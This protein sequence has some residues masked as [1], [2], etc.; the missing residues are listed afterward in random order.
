M[1]KRYIN[2][3]IGWLSFNDRVLQEAADKTTPLIERIKFLGIYS[4][5]MDEFF[6]VRV[7]TLKRMHKAGGKVKALLGGISPEKA[8]QEIQHIVISLQEKFDKIYEEIIDE[9]GKRNIFIIDE[10]ELSPEESL[11]V[12]SYFQKEI[13][14][15]LFPVMID[16]IAHLPMLKDHS[17]Y[18]AVV[19][20]KKGKGGPS[21]H[22]I[23]EIPQKL[24]RFLVLP[25]KDGK[26]RIMLIDDV[27]RVSIG[28]IF[29]VFRLDS[30][31]AYTIK[32]T[33]DAELDIDDDITKSFFEKISK[34]L[35]QRKAG[36]PVR[37][38]YDE[39]MPDTLLKI[40]IKKIRLSSTDN[41]IP[42]G[43][44]HNFKD[45]MNFPV[46]GGKDLTYS[47]LP[48]LPHRDFE[49]K[50]SIFSVIRKKDVFLHYP[51]H[52]FD[53]FV[54][55]IREASI[56]PKVT[57][58]RITLYRVAK[59]SKVVNALINAVR[60]GK[61]VTVIME[62]QARFDEEANIYWTDRLREE[63]ARIIHGV[64]NLKV[65]SKLCLISRKEKGKTVY[66]ANIATGNYNENTAKIYCDHGLL[67]SD[68]RITGDARRVFDFFDNNYKA[69]KYNNLLVS[70]FTVRETFIKH[71]NKE[72]KN[73]KNGLK[74]Y[75]ILK[76]NSLVDR[77]M[78]DNLYEASNAGVKID[79]IVRGTCSLIPGIRGMS[80]NIN[81]ISIVD[82]FLEHS[83]IFFFYNGGD[84][85]YFISSADWMTRNL[86]NRV[87][88]VCPILDKN[89]RHEL[90]SV[91]D[92]Q[93]KSSIK[94]RILDE[95]MI[96]SYRTAIKGTGISAQSE[97]YKYI[98]NLNL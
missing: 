34:S 57:N 51:Y 62:L 5:N 26:T 58:I 38:I 37:F 59:E 68:T 17:L 24:P 64:P 88:I 85:K 31:E 97:H 25:S 27:I 2:R 76:M 56:D 7:A 84:P 91:L 67:T 77:E 71:I 11:F 33:R 30:F 4:S 74:A 44:Y 23:I 12:K 29:S 47:P 80:E 78:I 96:N 89:I 94:T 39:S 40:L 63:G 90:E 60:N 9:L 79:L 61:N 35:K 92:I 8:L 55:F 42:G 19:M 22:A 36:N 3:E 41:L 48:P 43:R 46:V 75:I 15:A 50:H 86:D 20:K 28:E 83:R 13:R 95:S 87:E 66:Y 21:K 53:Y 18:L 16:K 72:I 14:S 10:K 54:D 69:G 1:E 82:R 32:M 93:L 52:S 6:R 49:G 73:A 81:A 45:F 98:E 70:P 65:H